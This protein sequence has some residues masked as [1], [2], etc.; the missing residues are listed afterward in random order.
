VPNGAEKFEKCYAAKPREIKNC[1]RQRMRGNK[2]DRS[3][4]PAR[5]NIKKTARQH[6]YAAKEEVR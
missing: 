3:I 4:N 6:K 2:I 1:A 5:Q